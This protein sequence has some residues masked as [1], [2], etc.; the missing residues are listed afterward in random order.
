MALDGSLAVTGMGDPLLCSVPLP[1]CREFN[2]HGFPVRLATNSRT[3]LKAA[4]ESWAGIPR[5]F[6]ET[7]VEVCCLVSHN[8]AASLPPPPVFRARRNLLT[9]VADTDNVVTCDLSA[10]LASVWVTG[11]VASNREYLRYH[12]LEAAVYCLLDIRHVV[13]IHAACVTFDGHG[14]LLAGDSGAGK[15][16]L[17]YACARRGWVYTSDDSSCLV[18]RGSGRMVLGNPRAFRFRET[19]GQLFPEFSGLKESRRAQGK[20]TIE[21]PTQA[22]PAIRTAR[23]SHVDYIVFL[24]RNEGMSRCVGLQSLGEEEAYRRLW[25]NPW[26]TELPGTEDRRAAVR[27]L[28]TAAS[29]E[30]T[31]SDLDAAIDRLEQL[32]R[33]ESQ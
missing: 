15:T 21:V 28:S 23:Q 3:V 31:Y 22:L 17:A 33:G 10:G 7:A 20:P 11:A 19:A 8:R 12:F 14:V 2:P 30:M 6:D 13:A 26:P 24:N 18:R 25:W 9:S 29:Y 1:Y 4:D 32:A 16:S 27:R 5:M